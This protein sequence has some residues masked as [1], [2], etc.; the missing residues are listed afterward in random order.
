MAAQLSGLVHNFSDNKCVLK[1]C[2]AFFATQSVEWSKTDSLRLDKFMM[3]R[4]VHEKTIKLSLKG[5]TIVYYEMLL[6]S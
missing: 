4:L 5:L 1:F 3:V 6:M 2:K